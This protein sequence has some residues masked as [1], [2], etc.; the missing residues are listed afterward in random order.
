MKIKTLHNKQ[1]IIDN[2]KTKYTVNL[3]F[4]QGTSETYKDKIS[5][6]IKRE[7]EKFMSLT[8]FSKNFN[9]L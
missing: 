9:K 5:K 2:G 6:L 3:H 7:T 1:L 4:K 8:N